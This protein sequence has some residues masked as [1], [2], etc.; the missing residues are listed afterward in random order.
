[1]SRDIITLYAPETPEPKVD[2]E[3]VARN[4]EPSHECKP[5]MFLSSDREPQLKSYCVIECNTCGQ[6]WWS[7]YEPDGGTHGDIHVIYWH[8]LR[9]YHWVIQRRVRN[10]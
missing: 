3:K 7:A 10:G 9:W 5:G 4:V 6:R 2:K 1:M 8:K